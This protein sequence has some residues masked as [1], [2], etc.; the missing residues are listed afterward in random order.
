MNQL[1]T[2]ENPDVIIL[3]AYNQLL[4]AVTVKVTKSQSTDIV[5]S[6]LRASKHGRNVT[7]MKDGKGWLFLLYMY[8]YCKVYHT[9]HQKNLTGKI[10][11]I[12]HADTF[13]WRTIS[14]HTYEYVCEY[15]IKI[16]SYTG[17]HLEHVHIANSSEIKL[18]VL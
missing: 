1:I 5:P 17:F 11:K 2:T 13:Q 7:H 18:V 14:V 10:K 12:K 3:R 8:M 16:P 9:V 15:P 4:V 6:D